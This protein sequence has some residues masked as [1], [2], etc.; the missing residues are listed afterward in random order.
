MGNG[1]IRAPNR[2]RLRLELL[3]PF[4]IGRQIA[5]TGARRLSAERQRAAAGAPQPDIL[6][7]TNL[8]FPNRSWDPDWKCWLAVADFAATD[9]RTRVTVDSPPGADVTRHE[10]E[11]LLNDAANER[12]DMLA[13]ILAQHDDFV[14]YFDQLLMAGPATHPETTLLVTIAVAVGQ[15]VVVNLKA[16]FN[17]ARPSQVCPS[18]LP[19]L[20]VPGHPAYPSG[21]ALQSY[22]IAH[23]VALVRPEM[24][25]S[26][27]ALA[28]RITRNREIAGFHYSSD[29]KAGQ[30]AAAS[31]FAIMRDLP[32]I[33]E[34]I[35]NAKREWSMP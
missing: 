8:T 33:Q 19:P 31:T 27:L 5:V 7:T 18:L 6:S 24:E 17:R 1:I 20:P 11:G 22:L 34:V 16:Q 2:V 28:A 23:L 29:G 13:E 30:Q 14:S 4:S 9:W 32:S 25:P 12:Q 15:L 3:F 26:L 21:H 35:A 10:I